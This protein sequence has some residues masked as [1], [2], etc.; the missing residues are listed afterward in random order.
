MHLQSSCKLIKKLHKAIK[1]K[2]AHMLQ[3]HVKFYCILSAISY[4][5]RKNYDNNLNYKNRVAY[6]LRIQ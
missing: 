5:I 2:F 1:T 6:A 3:I 4:C